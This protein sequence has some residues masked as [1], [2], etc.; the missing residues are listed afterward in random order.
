MR[1]SLLQAGLLGLAATLSASAFAAQAG[2]GDADKQKEEIAT[3][4]IDHGVIMVSE[5]GKAAFV[6]GVDEQR[7]VEKT[8]LM[9]AKDSKAVVEF[10]DNCDVTYEKPGVYEIDSSC[11]PIVWWGG[12]TGGVLMTGAV[13]TVGIGALVVNH[14]G[15]GGEIVIPLP[16]PP[17]S[18]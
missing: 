11:P 2:A 4:R 18:R 17:V 1:K 7:L 9:V 15:H 5:G 16:P 3:L 12:A 10:D 8:R 13:A 14:G 6:S